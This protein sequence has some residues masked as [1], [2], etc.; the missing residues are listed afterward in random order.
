MA[1][2]ASPPTTSSPSSSRPRPAPGPG[3]P[4][5]SP[6]GG[7]TCTRWPSPPTDDERFSRIAIVVDVESTPLEQITK[8]LFKLVNVVEIDRLAPEPRREAGDDAPQRP[9]RRPHHGQVIELVHVVQGRIVDV[10]LEQLTVVLVD[11]PSQ[12]DDFED[13]MR[14]FGIGPL[15]RTGR[16]ALPEPRT[17]AVPPAIGSGRSDRMASVYYEKDADPALIASRKVAVIGY[18]SPGH[19]HALNLKDSGVDVHIG[20]RERSA[21]SATA[22]AGGLQVETIAEATPRPT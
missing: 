15:Q 4:P 5:C 9:R 10:R 11:P 2:N 14:A 17:P 20:L 12:F 22:E 18:G 1:V 16:I 6:G 3:F 19:A 21:S 8:R 7:S 13:L